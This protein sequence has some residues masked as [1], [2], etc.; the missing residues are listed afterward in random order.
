MTLE[1]K[2]APTTELTTSETI[3][4]IKFIETEGP[5]LTQLGLLDD[6]PIIGGL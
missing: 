4:V 2:A 5:E 6:I 1:T 3:E